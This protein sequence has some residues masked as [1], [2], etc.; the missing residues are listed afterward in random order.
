MFILLS[1]STVVPLFLLLTISLS[2]HNVILTTGGYSFIPAKWS[3]EGYK[4]LLENGRIITKS[5]LVTIFI[6][7]VGTLGA[8]TVTT[9]AGYVLSR[10]TYCF[11]RFLSG[12]MF[13][14]M[15]F[16]AGL[17][18]TYIVETRYYGLQDNLLVCILPYLVNCWNA[19][20]LR[21]FYQ[22]L[23]YE[24][25]ESAIVDGAGEMTIFFKI[26]TPMVK[27]GIVTIAL[28]TM[29]SFWNQWQPSQIY[30][31]KADMQTLQ[32]YLFRMIENTQLLLEE[33]KQMGLTAD[34][35]PTEVVKFAAA[36]LVMG[37]T[38]AVFPFFQRYFVRG[39]NTG[40][41]KG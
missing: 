28:M 13:F 26:A 12:F 16:S 40:A 27:S 6:T 19:V 39:L 17:I 21:T 38:L 7:V 1:I 24:V 2:D 31:T 34:T 9:M 36:I 15:I 29:L 30:F 32:L 33:A 10:R 25:I 11:H 4:Y 14:T 5:Y 18:P 35:I 22:D 3:L 8:T 41:V 37:P 20:L 23:P